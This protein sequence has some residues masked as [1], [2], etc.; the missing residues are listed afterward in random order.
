MA[1]P[2]KIILAEDNLADVE[3]TQRAFEELTLPL[4]VV[5]VSDGQE[6]LHLLRMESLDNIALVM[7]K[8]NIG[9]IGGLDVLKTMYHDEELRKLPV[10][11]FNDSIDTD[12][13]VASYEHGANA[14]VKKPVDILEF[15]ETIRAIANFWGD[16]NVLPSYNSHPV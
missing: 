15:N 13:I 6:L 7:L 10:I 16:I 9:K 11:V 8:L 1:K 3:L 12:D 5:H 14:Y 4:E 2:R